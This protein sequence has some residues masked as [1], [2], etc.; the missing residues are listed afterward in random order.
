MTASDTIADYVAAW[1]AAR[2]HLPGD[3]DWARDLR[4]AAIDRFRTLGLP[5][6]RME[7]WKYT[8]LSPLNQAP[9]CPP[10]GRRSSP[11][12]TSAIW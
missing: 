6:P 9:S 8:K 4:G 11:A 2:D 5:N 7:A 1:E 10:R 3:A 12:A